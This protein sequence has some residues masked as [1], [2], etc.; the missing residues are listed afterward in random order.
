LKLNWRGKQKKFLCNPHII[1]SFKKNPK[2]TVH[3]GH[4]WTLGVAKI[5]FFDKM[6]SPQSIDSCIKNP[7]LREPQW[8]K[9]SLRGNQE[10]T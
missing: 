8:S 2:L 1:N 3:N 5:K 6:V 10:K 9:F 4:N 7:E